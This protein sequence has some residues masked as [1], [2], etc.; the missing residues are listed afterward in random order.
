MKN[1]QP[2]SKESLT[3]PPMPPR[4]GGACALAHADSTPATPTTCPT[5]PSKY[6]TVIPN[7][8]T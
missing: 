8:G 6:V 7:Q 5:K 2:K 4:A 1:F 3:R